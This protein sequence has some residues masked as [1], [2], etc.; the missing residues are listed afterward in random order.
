M[1]ETRVSNEMWTFCLWTL[2]L[3]LIVAG[4]VWSEYQANHIGAWIAICAAGFVFWFIGSAFARKGVPANPQLRHEFPKGSE[5]LCL[6]EFYLNGYWFQ[7][8]EQ[9]MPGGRKQFRLSATPPISPD[10]EA[11]VIRYLIHEGLS[12]KMWPQISARIEEEGN[13][14]FFA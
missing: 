3:I 2:L 9:G 13:W 5:E 4:V 6:R 8:Y 7:P 10:R 14:A 12:E 11:A 1:Q